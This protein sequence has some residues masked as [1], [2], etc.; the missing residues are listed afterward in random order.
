MRYVKLLL[1]LVILAAVFMAM[2]SCQLHPSPPATTE[3]EWLR[4]ED[5]C[6][7][8][9]K[10]RVSHSDVFTVGTQAQIQ[11]NNKARAVVCPA[12]ETAPAT[13]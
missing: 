10:V 13:P 1:P 4:R 3:T 6:S 9:L 12:K 11:D 8:W 7:V 5:I 2:T